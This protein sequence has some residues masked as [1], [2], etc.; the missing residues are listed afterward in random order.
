MTASIYQR[1]HLA[2]LE[3]GGDRYLALPYPH[4]LADQDPADPLWVIDVARDLSFTCRRRRAELADLQAAPPLNR[5]VTLTLP[6]LPGML[7]LSSFNL[8]AN[9]VYEAIAAM[10]PEA[11]RTPRDRC[12]AFA[13]QT[14]AAALGQGLLAALHPDPEFEEWFCRPHLHD[15]LAAS[16]RDQ[17]AAAGVTLADR[18]SWA[19][20][21]LEYP[22]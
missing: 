7:E 13:W 14:I 3:P 15:Q 17:L 2:Q 4:A 11:E 1:L 9:L 19:N 6:F 22:L 10:P 8:L 21:D 5:D 20:P 18:A 12:L 16:L